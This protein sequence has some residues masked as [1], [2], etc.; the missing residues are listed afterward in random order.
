MNVFFY[1]I[2][3]WATYDNEWRL[4]SYGLIILTVHPVGGVAS[5]MTGLAAPLTSIKVDLSA[6]VR[7]TQKLN[8]GVARANL[9]TH[10]SVF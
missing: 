4:E 2:L 10:S 9:E 8:R 3:G 7:L 5:R 6:N 1:R